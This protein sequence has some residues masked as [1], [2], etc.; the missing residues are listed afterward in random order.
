MGKSSLQ[1][2]TSLTNLVTLE[3]LLA[4]ILF[5]IC[6]KSLL[7][8]MFKGYV[9]IC[10]EVPHRKPLPSRVWCP[11]LQC[12]CIYKVF[13]LWHVLTKLHELSILKLSSRCFSLYSTIL[14]N[15]V[16]IGIA[17]VEIWFYFV[18]WSCKT[19]WSC[20]TMSCMWSD[21]HVTFW[22][23]TCYSKSQLCQ[24]SWW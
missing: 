4:D 9:N 11:L 2:L 5:L 3:V 22:V 7:E 8:Q 14:P 16:A 1:Y 13:S 6:H 19:T 24:V 21:G 17:V 12:H 10:G 23:G 18:M 15:L 20:E